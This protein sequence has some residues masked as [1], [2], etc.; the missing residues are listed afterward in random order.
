MKVWLDRLT[1]FIGLI[2]L[3]ALLVGGVGVGNAISSFLATRQHTIAILKCL[4]APERL[5]FA[6]YFLQLTALTLVG[7]GVG[8]AVEGDGAQPRNEPRAQ[9]AQPRPHRC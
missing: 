3:A 7:I 9:R 4:G 1:E 2:G 6:T 8:V 5:V